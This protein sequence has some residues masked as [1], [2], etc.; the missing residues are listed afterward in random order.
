MK[1]LNPFERW[2]VLQNVK[3]VK[4]G[5]DT[6]EARVAQLKANGYPTIAGAV[7]QALTQGLEPAGPGDW[8]ADSTTRELEK[9]LAQ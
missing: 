2:M 1:Q 9:V 7:E 4:N 3:D 8:N 6:L 5:V